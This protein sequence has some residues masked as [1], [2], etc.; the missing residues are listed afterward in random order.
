MHARRTL[1]VSLICLL[2]LG[3]ACN[4]FGPSET[5][6]PETPSVPTTTPTDTP[7]PSPT[8]TS[9]LAPSPTP[10]FM[11]APSPTPTGEL[12]TVPVIH[13]FRA[14]VPEADPGD[15]ITLEWQ[16]SGAISATLYHVPP[17]FQL[18]QYGWD[19][20]PSGSYVYQISPDERNASHFA[21]FVFSSEGAYASA[22]AAVTL[23]CPV[24]W[25]FSPE[26]DICGS[27]TLI[28]N[29]AEQHFEHGTM[30]W[31]EGTPEHGGSAVY[32]LYEDESTTKWNRFADEWDESQPVSDPSLTPPSGFFQPVRGFGLVW[33]EGTGVRDRL[34]WAT[35][36]EA[37]FVTTV[38]TTTLYKYNSTYI[39]ALDSNVWH[40][41]P[42]RGSWDKIVVQQNGQ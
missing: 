21:L 36:Q 16:S 10:T 33:R 18:P 23:R 25:F 11:L 37:A 7:P 39:R 3:C 6:T 4:L 31:V 19:V 9:T 28:T 42:E 38:Q 29:A 22:S 14:D 5:A 20:A 30:I 24:A 2:L 35:D 26:P 17:S 13:Y 27:D 15:T 1:T 32:V 41:G 12:E 8:P 34:G 40:L